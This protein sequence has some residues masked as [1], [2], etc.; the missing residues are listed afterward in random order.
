MVVVEVV[1][2][3]IA[4]IPIT[5]TTNTITSTSSS[6]YQ[7]CC[8]VHHYYWYYDN[9][10]GYI[11]QGQNTQDMIIWQMVISVQ[12]LNADSLLH[13]EVFIT[14]VEGIAK[15]QW[16]YSIPFLHFIRIVVE[17]IALCVNT[18]S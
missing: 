8:C 3:V 15:L 14:Y 12:T 11:T 1:V 7:Y 16:E 13:Y 17:F 2:V 4:L 18:G 6:S 5:N 10:N 9:Y